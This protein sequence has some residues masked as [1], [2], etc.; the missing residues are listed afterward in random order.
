MD[1]K[2]HW[3]E[4]IAQQII[5]KRPN[6]DEYVC[7]AGISPS[8]SV[9]IGNFRD[10]ATSLFVAKALE[11]RGKKVRLLFS[12][13]E[14]DRLRK[15]PSNVAAITENFE[16]NIGRAYV[17]IENPFKDDLES[18][19]YAEHF[20]KEF[21]D[22][23]QPFGIKLDVRHQAEMYRS[24]K[25]A[26]N[27]IYALK[28]RKEI[29]DILD[30]Y[31]TQ[32]STQE[33]RDNYYPVGIYCPH[34]G[35]DTTK[36]TSLSDDCTKA[37][38]ECKCGHIG[39]FDFT[40][41]FNCK[42][43][44]KV[45]WAMRWKYEQVDFE[46]GGIDHASPNGSY[47]AGKDISREI[48]G[49]E[50]PIF[51]GY[52]F[53]G[54]K[55]RAGKM[56][57]SSGLNLTPKTLLRIYQ[58]EVLLWLYA[59]TEPNKEFDFCFD[60]GILRQYFEFDKMLTEMECGKATEWAKTTMNFIQIEGRKVFPVPFNLLVQLGSVVDFNEELLQLVLAKIGHNYSK[61]EMS[62]RLRLAKCWL[63]ECSPENINRIRAFR[64]W[65]VFDTFTPEEKNETK[66]LYNY[67]AEGGYSLEELQTELYAIPR[68]VRN[69]TRED[70]ALKAI[71]GKFFSNVY[72]LLIDKEKGPRL[73]LFLY[74]ISPDSY[75]HLLDFSYPKTE[76]EIKAAEI[77]E[78]NAVEIE[79]VDKENDVQYGDADPVE[80]IKPEVSIDDFLKIDL[81]VCKIIKCQEIRKSHS[82]YKMTLDDGLKKREIV[83]SIKKY[84]CPEEL[85]GRKIIVVANL[86][87]TRITGVTSEGMLL[88]G[89]NNACGCKV[90]FVDDLIP[91]GTQIK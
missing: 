39:E 64:N 78:I 20:E 26:E 37:H 83:S 86:A 66:L 40:K 77:T 65:E 46:P 75:L 59:K 57:S 12:W 80:P 28:K 62:E 31:K 63:E 90:V 58:P 18:K 74:A 79:K 30:R 23:I 42:L 10:V 14:L 53:I 45:D 24:G 84:Y 61:E 22:S 3:A 72:K 25:Y 67:L 38:F 87:P 36:I 55:G 89:T 41:D 49:Y 16:T 51:Q 27:V 50:A 4:A 91:E 68:Q 48:F 11:K 44:W 56:S 7:A 88:A 1:E 69:I 19:T 71:Q 70:K 32:D 43:Q 5:N 81:R 34:C 33:E 82:C 85:I 13:D 47:A 9:H 73:Y 29:F 21:E 60:D 52:G 76:A 54:L 2:I 6:K 17:D 35:K 15:V 8:G